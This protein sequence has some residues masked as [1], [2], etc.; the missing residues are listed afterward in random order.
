MYKGGNNF[1]H[2]NNKKVKD[3][4]IKTTNESYICLRNDYFKWF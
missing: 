2:N 1:Q 4:N 3:I